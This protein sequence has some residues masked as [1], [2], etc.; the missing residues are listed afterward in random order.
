MIDMQKARETLEA[1]GYSC[2]YDRSYKCLVFEHDLHTVRF[3]PKSE[4]FA[5]KSVQDGR[6]FKNL[7]KQLW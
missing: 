7:L 4:W 3:F 6:G 5:G 1:R 2:K